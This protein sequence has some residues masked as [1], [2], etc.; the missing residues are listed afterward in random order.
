MHE[1]LP[2][3]PNLEHIADCAKYNYAF[4]VTELA[5]LQRRLAALTAAGGLDPEESRKLQEQ[6]LNVWYALYFGTVVAVRGSDDPPDGFH[7]AGDN[8]YSDGRPVLVI[9]RIEPV[10]AMD[11]DDQCDGFL[12]NVGAVTE[13][14]AGVVFAINPVSPQKDSRT[15]Q[16]QSGRRNA[17]SR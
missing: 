5:A 10:E 11:W 17:P 1:H 4:G 15:E 6:A 14:P 3:T 13:R 9:S 12:F 2:V 8:V 16:S 7:D